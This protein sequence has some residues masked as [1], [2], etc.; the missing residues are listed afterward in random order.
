LDGQQAFRWA[1]HDRVPG[2]FSQLV[3]A[4]YDLQP[5]AKPDDI[6]AVVVALARVIKA[7]DPNTQAHCERLATYAVATG[8]SLGLGAEDLT[9][10]RHGSYLHDLGKT[11]IPRS[12]LWKPGPLTRA[13][14][15]CIQEHARIGDE[16]CETL[17]LLRQVRPIIRSHHER[18]DGS[19]YPD[20]LRGD[21]I[22]LV[23]QLIGIADVYDALVSE[24][25]YKAAVPPHAAH[26]ELRR[27][28]R[29]GWRSRALVEAF[30]A[31]SLEQSYWPRPRH[32]RSASIH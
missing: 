19:G 22:P 17:P 32:T 21:D 9:T 15:A 25:P 7:R 24:R 12:I 28:A 18:L 13:E 5:I 16:L 29:K 26:E 23:A 2:T 3:R 11:A 4:V 8:V 1:R 14:L 27:E 31:T 30:I 10:L 20:G 6:E